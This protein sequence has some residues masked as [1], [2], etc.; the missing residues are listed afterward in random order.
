MSATLQALNHSPAAIAAH[1]HY[2]KL[3][4][5]GYPFTTPGS[6]RENCGPNALSKGIRTKRESNPTTLCLGVESTN[7][8]TTVL[9]HNSPARRS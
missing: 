4:P 5:A 3:I 8:Y 2:K 1:E 7:Q 9:P 6:R